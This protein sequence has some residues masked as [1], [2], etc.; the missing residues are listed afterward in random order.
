MDLC[1]RCECVP[2]APGS[3][4]M[5]Y[6]GVE[7]GEN[8]T[9]IIPYP[10][11]S[12]QVSYEI[13]W[14]QHDLLGEDNRV[15][16][17]AQEHHEYTAHDPPL[18]RIARSPGT[19]GFLQDGRRLNLNRSFSSIQSSIGSGA[20]SNLRRNIDPPSH[21][22]NTLDD[23]VTK[24][25]SVNSLRSEI[26]ALS[27]GA[28]Y[29]LEDHEWRSSSGWYQD[30]CPIC[31]GLRSDT[32]RSSPAQDQSGAQYISAVDSTQFSSVSAT[33][34]SLE[35]EDQLFPDGGFG[36]PYA[37]TGTRPRPRP[38]FSIAELPEGGGCCARKEFLAY[39]L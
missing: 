13:W 26:S 29:P 18:P 17:A 10:E 31:G 30:L 35:Y 34:V 9:A 14:Q 38:L 19:N 5:G 16:V 33:T 1:L 6:F 36:V 28:A 11:E 32:R 21:D 15:R 4:S 12:E 7:L 3:N 20:W 22:A 27:I 8:G 2:V 25:R 23:P 37:Q 39:R 24:R